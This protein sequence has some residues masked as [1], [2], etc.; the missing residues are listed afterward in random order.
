MLPQF[1]WKLN[2]E[3]WCLL[4]HKQKMKVCIQLSNL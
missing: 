2:V 3:K 4:Q 1:V